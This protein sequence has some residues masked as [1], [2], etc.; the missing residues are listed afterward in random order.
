MTT[1]NKNAGTPVS[2][3][4]M[5]AEHAAMKQFIM[6]LLDGSDFVSEAYI[7]SQHTPS[8]PYFIDVKASDIVDMA[9]LLGLFPAIPACDESEDSHDY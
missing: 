3:E 1:E 7:V 2:V 5:Q 6:R 4:R 8:F 9:Y